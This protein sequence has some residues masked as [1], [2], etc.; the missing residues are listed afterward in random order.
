MLGGMSA[1]WNQTLQSLDDVLRGT[2]DR[3]IVVTRLI[4]AP[5][6]RVPA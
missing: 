2:I 1:G 3:Q 4:S 5:P 6:D